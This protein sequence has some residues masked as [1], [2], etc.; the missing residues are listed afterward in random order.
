MPD[1][2]KQEQFGTRLVAILL[3]AT[4]LLQIFFWLFANSVEPI[5][6][7]LPFSMFFVSM[8]IVLEFFLLLIL[9]HLDDN[10]E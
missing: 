10:R 6:L 8:L 7:G 4:V 9:Y 2:V 3:V 5:I 1:K